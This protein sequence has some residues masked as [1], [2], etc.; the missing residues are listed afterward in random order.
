MNHVDERRHKAKTADAIAHCTFKKFFLAQIVCDV[1]Y[2][3]RLVIEAAR[4]NHKPLLFFARKSTL[5]WFLIHH[6]GKLTAYLF[7]AA[8]IQSRVSCLTHKLT[9]IGNPF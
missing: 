6:S 8:T 1:E 2:L 3:L 4:F 5:I 9:F 7:A